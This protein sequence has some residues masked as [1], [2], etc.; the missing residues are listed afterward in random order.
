[1]THTLISRSEFLGQP[2]QT[3]ITVRAS[4]SRNSYDR[5]RPLL[6][7]GIAL[8]CSL[9]VAIL[10]CSAIFMRRVSYSNNFSSIMWATGWDKADVPTRQGDRDGSDP[11]P[12]YLGKANMN[13]KVKAAGARDEEVALV[14]NESR[15]DEHANMVVKVVSK[16]TADDSD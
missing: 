5:K 15:T 7:Y 8:G 4:A 11:L 6:I 14:K 1:M 9:L 12:E 13:L 16:E 2:T 10:G 3:H